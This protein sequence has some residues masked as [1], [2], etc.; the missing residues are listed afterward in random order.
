MCIHDVLRMSE[1]KNEVEPN[2][3]ILGTDM[4]CVLE[5]MCVVHEST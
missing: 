1:N 2:K 4:Q 3:F 5:G